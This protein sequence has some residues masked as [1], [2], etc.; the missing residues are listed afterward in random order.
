MYILMMT[1]PARGGGRDY[2]ITAVSGRWAGDRVVVLGDYTE[3][4]DLPNV[5]NA[6]KIYAQTEFFDDITDLIADAFETVFES[7]SK[8]RVED[9]VCL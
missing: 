1:S 3:D 8:V 2:P 5:P 6:S 9:G 4:A 7:K